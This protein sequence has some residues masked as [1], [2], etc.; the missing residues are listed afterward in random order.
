MNVDGDDDD[1]NEF[2]MLFEKFDKNKIDEPLTNQF[3]IDYDI[4]KA[5]PSVID[6]PISLKY[7]RR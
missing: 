3:K 5:R 2:E 6:S 7:L 1:E 4:D